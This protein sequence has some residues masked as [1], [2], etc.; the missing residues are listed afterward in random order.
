MLCDPACINIVL[1]SY[2][3]FMSGSTLGDDFQ[4]ENSSEMP[5][6]DKRSSVELAHVDVSS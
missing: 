4:V 5:Q 6:T 1:A 2:L 3:Y